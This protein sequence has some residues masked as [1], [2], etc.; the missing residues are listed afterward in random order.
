[1]VGVDLSPKMLAQAKKKLVYD[2][3]YGGDLREWVKEEAAKRYVFLVFPI[4]S[5][6]L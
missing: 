1:M 5:P 6:L 4:T 2:K 3:L